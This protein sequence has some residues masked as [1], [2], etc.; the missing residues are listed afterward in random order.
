MLNPKGCAEISIG[1]FGGAN[2]DMQPTDLPQGLSPDCSD[3]AFLPGSVHTRPSLKVFSTLGSGEVIYTSSYYKPDGTVSQLAF[4]RSGGMFQDGVIFGAPRVPLV[5]SDSGY[6]FFTANAFGKAY[7]AVSDGNVGADVPLQLTA[8]GYV[9]RVSQ[10]GVGGPPG[11]VLESSTA[12]Q[13]SPGVHQVVCIFQT[14]TGYLTAPS[15][16]VSWTASGG[17]QV[18]VNNIP[19]GPSNV[20]ARI[21]AFT[22]ANGANFFYL[23]IPP[24][25]NGVVS[26]TSTVIN[27]NTTLTAS[28]DFSD[29]ALF[30]GTAIDIPGNNLFNLQVLGPCLGFFYYASRLFAWGERNKVQNFLNMGFEGGAYYNGGLAL[31]PLGW[32]VNNPGDGGIVTTGDYG[33]AWMASTTT[34]SQSAYQDRFGIPILQPNTQYTYRAWVSGT[35]IATL[36]SA[37]TGFTSSAQLSSISGEFREV[38]FSVKTPNVIP[39]DFTLTLSGN[40]TIDEV[41]II[42]TL[43]P[44]IQ[45]A[46]V[47][48]VDNPESFDGVT[49]ILGPSGDPHPI[50]GM[51]E[52]KDLLCLLTAGPQGS[53][54]ET[55]DDPAGEPATWTIR[56]IASECGLISA[57]GTTKFED[58]FAWTSDTGLRM[59]DGS[60]VEKMSQEIQP[61]WDGINEAYKNLVVLANDPYTRRLYVIAKQITDPVST[62]SMYVMDYRDLNT[63]SL[64]ANAGTLHIGYTGKVVTT[65]LTRKW[66]PWTMNINYAGLITVNNEC[67]MAF[68]GGQGE[69]S[70]GGNI[71]TLAEGVIDGIDDFFGPFWQNSYY[72]TYF[73]VS[74]E[75][76]SQNQLSLHRLQHMFMSLNCEGVGSVFV[77]PNL[78]RI[79]N[80]ANPTRALAVT[81]DLARDL[82]FGLNLAAERISYRVCC[83]PAG[84]QPAPPTAPAGFKL[85]SMTVAIKNHGFSPIRGKNS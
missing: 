44:Y 36:S 13:I 49:G 52:R 55:Q 67:F 38:A 51:E 24:Q 69:S 76:A 83:Q 50:L 78:D 22:G 14:R 45:S 1:V 68:C 10:D 30:A 80:P 79:N 85:S 15:P 73:F 21:L 43:D 72:S 23:P 40:A 54:Y 56:H 33:W 75:E 65:D 47:S 59:F 64:M 9:D 20:I 60:N 29:E 28:F 27:D 8:E 6:K 3:V 4:T 11:Q 62:N 57:W 25:V 42:Y 41:E 18:Q 77:I 32:T 31:L 35:S 71:Y 81:P 2:I 17:K 26:G 7:V 37:S 34:I 70:A 19:I 84:P 58:W 46:K 61:W 16:A 48:Y 53:L 5:G 39:P 82:E 63:A 66:T 12:G 74:A